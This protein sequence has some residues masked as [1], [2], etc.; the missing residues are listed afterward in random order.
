[1]IAVVLKNNKQYYMVLEFKN[2]E[3]KL[4]NILSINFNIMLICKISNVKIDINN[5]ALIIS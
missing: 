1:L 5:Y 2:K 3:D 4:E